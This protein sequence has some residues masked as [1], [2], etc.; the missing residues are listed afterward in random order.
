MTTTCAPLPPA[1]HLKINVYYWY[2]RAF[3]FAEVIVYLCT[4]DPLQG[5]P[6]GGPRALREDG[7]DVI[8]QFI[9]H[10]DRKSLSHLVKLYREPSLMSDI[11]I[12][13]ERGDRVFRNVNPVHIA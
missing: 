5:D 11:S 1:E 9:G 8:V 12:G 6:N 3:Y 7:G 2:F 13:A 4:L 10:R